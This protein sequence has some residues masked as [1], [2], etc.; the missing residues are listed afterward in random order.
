[1]QFCIRI[2]A[3]RGDPAIASSPALRRM[4]VELSPTPRILHSV[5]FPLCG[6]TSVCYIMCS[7]LQETQS[8]VWVSLGT[9]QHQTWSSKKAQVQGKVLST[10]YTTMKI[11]DMYIL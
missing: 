11:R 4:L 7:G 3:R 8:M 2:T 5:N 1:M 9:H 6:V 10:K